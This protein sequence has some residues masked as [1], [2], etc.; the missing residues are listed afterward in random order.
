MVVLPFVSVTNRLQS[1]PLFSRSLSLWGPILPFLSLVS[2]HDYH[3]MMTV[4]NDDFDQ[5]AAESKRPL[6]S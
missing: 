1:S 5:L 4:L 6:R 3:Q 2:T